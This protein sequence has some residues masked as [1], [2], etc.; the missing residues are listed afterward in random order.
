MR[1]LGAVAPERIP[2]L[3]RA[4]DAAA[5]VALSEGYGLGAIEAVACGVPLVVSETAPVA[6][7][8]P[9][10]A[11]VRVD[12]TDEDAIL[13]G[14]RTALGLV[15]DDP[16]GQAVADRHADVVQARRLLD[17]LAAAASRP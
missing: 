7:E 14:L 16:A 2:D 5:L 4:A 1:L 8:L 17:V 3:L 10:T 12:P 15:R 9:A 6:H 13:A 11:A